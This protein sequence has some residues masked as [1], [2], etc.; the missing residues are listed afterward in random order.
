MIHAIF[1][2]MKIVKQ[3]LRLAYSFVVTSRAYKNDDKELR[4]QKTEELCTLFARV[5]QVPKE[6]AGEVPAAPSHRNTRVFIRAKLI[7]YFLV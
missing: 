6:K 7:N 5:T 2:F 3:Q 1:L 4:P